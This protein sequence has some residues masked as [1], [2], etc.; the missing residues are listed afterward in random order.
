M[1]PTFRA[2]ARKALEMACAAEERGIDGVFVF[3]HLW[4]MGSP[5][6][7][8]LAARLVLSAVAVRTERIRLGTLVSRVGL[9]P[10]GALVAELLAVEL[11]S[12][13]RLIAGLGVGDSKSGDEHVR[14]G[15]EMAPAGERRSELR[16]VGSALWAAGL[17][18]WV[19]GG[20]MATNQA[21]IDI[22]AVV[23]LWDASPEAVAAVLAAGAREVTWGGPLPDDPGAAAARLSALSQAGASWAVVGAP[24][25]I[26]RLLRIR[27]A[28]GVFEPGT[29]GEATGER[30]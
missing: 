12:A 6:R 27:D 3:D 30:L 5:N 18:V 16:E 28:A 9:L 15:I 22:G 8:A 24:G 1:L 13:G 4:P 7:P 10:A 21:G 26:E 19:G 11:E 23:N 25:S 17:E 29:S 20:S 14:T 2:D